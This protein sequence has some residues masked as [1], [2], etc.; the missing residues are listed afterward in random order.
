MYRI[1]PILIAPILAAFFLASCA[2]SSQQ[3]Q[4]AQAANDGARCQDHGFKPG[5]ADYDQCLTDLDN[6]RT[7]K[8]RAALMGRLQGRSPMLN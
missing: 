1:V 4:E 2:G 3:S 7:Q 6:L 5:S 8:D